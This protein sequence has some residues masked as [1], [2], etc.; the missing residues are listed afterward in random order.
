MAFEPAVGR[1]LITGAS[2]FVGR[3]L[4]QRMDLLGL[5]VRGASR[6]ALGATGDWV[7]VDVRGGSTDWRAALLDCDSVVHAAGRAHVLKEQACDPLALFREANVD[8]TLAL[9]EQALMMGV[10]RFV[11]IS[12][13]GVSG[14]VTSTGQPFTEQQRPQPHAPYAVSKLE[15]EQALTRLLA[16]TSME[17]VI[18][19]PPLVYASHAPGNFARLLGLVHRRLP[20]PFGSVENARS[21][22]ALE[23]LVDFLMCCLRHPSAAGQT[24]LVADGEDLSTAELIR[25]LADG[26]GHTPRLVPVPTALLALGARLTGR[27]SMYQQLCLSLQVDTSKARSLLGWRPPVCA[28]TAL[29]QTSRNWYDSRS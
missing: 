24:F 20:L 3:H 17:L 6:Q 11:F 27:M 25:V 12:S 2:G 16:G 22:V 21:M 23:N 1:C 13:I 28:R 7:Q 19:R 26:M 4:F 9:A 5:P 14:N 10:K 18:V 15:A 8:V 29:R